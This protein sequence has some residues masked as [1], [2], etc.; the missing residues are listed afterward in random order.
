M[1]LP[2]TKSPILG[3]PFLPPYIKLPVS[4]LAPPGPILYIVP[5]PGE[6]VSNV[7]APAEWLAI[8]KF[9]LLVMVGLLKSIAVPFVT[10]IALD[11]V[12]ARVGEAGFPIT[13][14]NP[15]I[16]W[17]VILFLSVT[18]SPTFTKA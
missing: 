16:C 18:I 12:N 15:V 3:I 11:N 6:V 1:P 8:S 14:T 2:L 17:P 9:L 5:K 4:L 7:T 10:V 13:V